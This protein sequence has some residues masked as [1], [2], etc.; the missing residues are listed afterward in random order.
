MDP[1]GRAFWGV[2][3]IDP[4]PGGLEKSPGT[5]SDP[6]AVNCPPPC[7][8]EPRISSVGTDPGPSFVVAVNCV[9]VRASDAAPA[10]GETE[11]P[12]KLTSASAIA[13]SSG[14]PAMASDR[15][16]IVTFAEPPGDSRM[17]L[18]SAALPASVPGDLSVN[19][20]PGA[21]VLIVAPSTASSAV[22]LR[23]ALLTATA[24]SLLSTSLPG[25]APAEGAAVRV[26]YTVGPRPAGASR[27]EASS[28]G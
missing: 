28:D 1:S 6:F 25:A 24:R 11:N 23:F 22:P 15:F 16:L 7:A 8:P 5:W 2:T 10:T 27:P 19:S 14:A 13:E 12:A 20:A 9:R 3:R 18:R 21:R 17:P 4:P 26:T